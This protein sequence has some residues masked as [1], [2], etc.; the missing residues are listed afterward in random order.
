MSSV[1]DIAKKLN[2]A[3]NNDKLALTA[4]IQPT[5]NRLPC[6]DLGADFPLYGGLPYGRIVTVSGKEHS[7]KTTGACVW[8]SAYQRANPGKMCVYVD[9]EH[10]LD[11]IFQAQ[12]TGLDLNNLLYINPERMS[13]EQIL[14]AVEELQA[15]D[16]IGMIVIDS[17]AALISGR[18]YDTD[19]EKDNGMAGSIAKPL[20]KF[21]TQMLSPL[22]EKGNILLLINQ[23]RQMGTMY[24]GAPILDEPCG[25]APKYY[26]SIK[27]RFG[28]R[29]FTNGDKVDLRD[30][31]N[32][33][34]F[35][36]SFA[37][38][39]N[40]TAS[41]QRGGGFLTF[42]YDRGLDWSFDLL[43]VA[44]KYDFIQR[45][46]MQ[47]YVLTD[48]N[49]GDSY[50]DEET[51]EPLSFRGKAKVKEYLE[52][53][54]DFQIKYMNMLNNYISAHQNS[55]GNLLDSRMLAEIKAEESSVEK[56]TPSTTRKTLNE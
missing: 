46:N 24:N 38:T 16:N 19:V 40:K 9:V 32:A 29:T 7:G 20:K 49:T 13:G 10:S 37:T 22:S 14:D 28:T 43:E 44:L 5:Y 47:T 33:D 31:E 25:H 34:G 26:A 15:S 39:K 55:Y 54:I 17:I 53:H 36:L 51:G 48:L 56:E 1:L 52:S 6:G 2:K 30:G 3:F 21:I 42:R 41:T 23:V 35:R 8:L 11:M 12:M 45:P 27:L 4:D 18:D 50:T